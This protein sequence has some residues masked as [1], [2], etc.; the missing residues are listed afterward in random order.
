MEHGI[1]N[2]L[3]LVLLLILVV[4]IWPFFLSAQSCLPEGIEFTT[5]SQ[6]DSFPIN[7]PNCTEIE[8][9]VMISGGL[10]ISN[11]L[12]LSSVNTI[13]GHLVIVGCH[14]L[15]NLA[16]LEGLTRIDSILAFQ[17][18]GILSSLSGLEGLTSIGHDLIILGNPSLTDLSGLD[19]LNSVEGMIW[20][21][22]NA[23][24]SFEGME[25]LETIGG[26]LWVIMNYSLINLSGLNNLTNIGAEL[27]ITWNYDLENLTGLESLETIGGGIRIW[28]N[29][30]LAE[31]NA[32]YGL[33]DIGGQ[34]S[35]RGND[36]L[37]SL[38]G[39]DNISAS[40][41]T[42]MDIFLNSSLSTC[43]VQSVCDYLSAPNGDVT[44]GNNAPGCNSEEEVEDSCAILAIPEQKLSLDIKAYP[45]PFSTSTTIEYE[46]YTK[47]NIQFTVYNMMGEE[48]YFKGK[49]VQAPGPHSINLSLPNQP[50]GMYYAVLYSGKIMSVVKLH[51]Q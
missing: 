39:L 20:A 51:K 2:R 1:R 50:A 15:S 13:G 3:R 17:Q 7:Y 30:T 16:G 45:N 6:I 42:E 43:H 8:G 4:L 27:Y 48:V 44:I 5:Q 22:S 35:I 28:S 24:T 26:N 38:Y 33:T 10:D 21:E 14:A 34:L 19:G 40:S 25:S 11:L 47:S 32:L 41:I 23:L 29:D 18:N 31:I 9:T 46:L 37:V 12:G 36:D 49:G